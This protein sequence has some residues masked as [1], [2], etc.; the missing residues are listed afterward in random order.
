MANAQFN[1]IGTAFIAHFYQTFDTNRAALQT[2]YN[3]RSLLTYEGK[4]FMGMQSLM[5]HLTS[6]LGFQTVQ[7]AT[8]TT[9]CQPTEANGIVV[10]VT[11]K[12]AVDGST[13]PLNFAESFVL[14]PTPEGS[15]Y[16]HNDTF[17]LNYA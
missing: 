3:E 15:W 1:E 9:D 12:L 2:L 6:G 11:G 10:F 13:N 5:T 7:H 16:I 4:Q 17:R 8:T 14:M